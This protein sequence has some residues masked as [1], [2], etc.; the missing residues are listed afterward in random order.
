MRGEFQGDEG[1]GHRGGSDAGKVIGE[2]ARFN[3]RL[4]RNPGAIRTEHMYDTTTL[5]QV[6]SVAS[7]CRAIFGLIR[8]SPQFQPLHSTDDGVAEVGCFVFSRPPDERTCPRAFSKICQQLK[9]GVGAAD[10]T[11]AIWTDGCS[12]GDQFRAGERIPSMAPGSR[13]PLCGFFVSSGLGGQMARPLNSL[14]PMRVMTRPGSVS[15]A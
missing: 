14:R 5:H 10:R 13:H 11:A 6:G 3:F 12:G 2:A 9:T 15:M 4:G 7:C 8:P 1:A